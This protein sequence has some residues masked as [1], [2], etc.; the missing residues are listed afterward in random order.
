MDKVKWLNDNLWDCFNSNMVEAEAQ[1]EAK[2]LFKLAC[3][4]Q[5]PE[6]IAELKE[7]AK[8]YDVKLD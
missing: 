1:V 8:S 6:V 3:E 5:T 4:G 2:H 7:V